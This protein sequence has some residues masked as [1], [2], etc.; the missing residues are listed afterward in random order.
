VDN[1]EA[2]GWDLI[3]SSGDSISRCADVPDEDKSK[4]T[5]LK[6]QH[7]MNTMTHQNR[8]SLEKH[9]YRNDRVPPP[10]QGLGLK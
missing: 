4:K 1:D 2:K 7:K 3:T 10:S 9:Q 5:G 8:S 6:S